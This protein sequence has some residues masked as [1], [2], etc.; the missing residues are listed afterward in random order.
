MLQSKNES[1]TSTCGLDAA[2]VDRTHTVEINAKHLSLNL[3]QDNREQGTTPTLVPT[4]VPIPSSILYK[5]NLGLSTNVL[6]LG[7]RSFANLVG[8]LLQKGANIT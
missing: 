3:F 1:Q 4:F 7:S 2:L 8:I 5:E 6:P